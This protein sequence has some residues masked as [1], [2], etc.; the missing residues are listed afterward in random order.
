MGG[1]AR[2]ELHLNLQG[3]WC[4]RL[5][6]SEDR[7]RAALQVVAFLRTLPNSQRRDCSASLENKIGL[8]QNALS[9]RVLTWEEIHTMHQTGIAFGSHTL[10]HP[11]VSQL[12]PEELEH[13][14][15]ASKVLLEEK[16]GIPVLDFAFPFV[17]PSH[18][19]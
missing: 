12:A 9:S 14:L 5:N 3:P 4:L 17:H 2:G 15:V 10:T 11:V 13:E 7:L 16:L 18:R 1:V 19:H 6:S 8:P